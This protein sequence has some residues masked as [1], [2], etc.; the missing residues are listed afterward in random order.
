MRLKKLL[1]LLIMGVVVLA[2]TVPLVSAQDDIIR[3]GMVN[4][5]QSAPY[6]IGMSRA[7]QEEAAVYENVELII[8]DANGDIAKLVSDVEDVLA[9]N[10]D[11]IIISAGW[12]NSAPAALDA[13]QAAGVPV[14]LV[15]RKLTGGEY[16]S[17]IGPDNYIIGVQDGEYIV[18]RLNGEGVLVVLRGGPE[19]N[20]I[21]LDRTNGVLSVVEQSNIEV[22]MAPNFGDWSEDGGF[23]LME[24]MLAQ[25]DRIDA[26]FCE[27]DS[28]CLGAQ[29]AIADAGRSDEM[30]LVGVD[31][32]KEALV[33]IMNGTN[34]A[35]TGLNNSDQIGRAAFHRLMAILA[36]ARPPKDTAFP[37]P[38]ITI[39]NVHRFYNPDSVF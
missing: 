19:D 33:E 4:L 14:V 26:V 6:F 37:S 16:T 36:G 35:A 34:Y 29:K 1:S 30:F 20:T 28:M 2:A 24:D 18:E 9:Q 8:T 7:V 25:Y 13:I 10:V 12:I 3:I 38:R 5:T 21:G 31:G 15:D 11:G 22:I 27:N 23:T 17:W 39:D 32:Q